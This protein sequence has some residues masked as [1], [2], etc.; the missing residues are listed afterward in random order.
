MWGY[1][2][3]FTDKE[4]MDMNEKIFRFCYFIFEGTKPPAV[5]IRLPWAPTNRVD[6]WA[7]R[8]FHLCRFTETI[9]ALTASLAGIGAV[10][11]ITL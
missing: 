5:R 10:A 1:V 6:T 8:R 4:G 9:T 11:W 2:S 3:P 7:L